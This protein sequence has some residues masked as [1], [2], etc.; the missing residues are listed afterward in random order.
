MRGPITEDSADCRQ[1]L[2]RDTERR[3][4][5]HLTGLAVDATRMA[6]CKLSLLSVL[7][8]AHTHRLRTVQLRCNLCSANAVLMCRKPRWI[9]PTWWTTDTL[10]LTLTRLLLRGDVRGPV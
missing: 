5:G 10:E 2:Q 1:S 7:T 3:G 9:W 6:C 8:A 4:N